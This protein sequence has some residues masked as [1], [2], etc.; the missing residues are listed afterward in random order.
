MSVLK[1][2]IRFVYVSILTLNCTNVVFHSKTRPFVHFKVE[3]KL[4]ASANSNLN[5]HNAIIYRKTHIFKCFTLK[6]PNCTTVNSDFKMHKCNIPLKNSPFLVFYALQK[7]PQGFHNF[8]RSP[9]PRYCA[10][11]D[12]FL[13]VIVAFW[14]P[15]T[16]SQHSNITH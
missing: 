7:N 9:N 10:V 8:S 16:P 4:C 6:N 15:L 1:W 13:V 12:E 14:V 3:N 11:N 2:K 5:L